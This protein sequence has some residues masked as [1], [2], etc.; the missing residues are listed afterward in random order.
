[1]QV[2][3]KEKRGYI[4]MK[5]DPYK[6]KERFLAWKSKANGRI[7]ELSE[8]N[9]EIL[10]R[11]ISDMEFGLNVANKSVKGAKDSADEIASYRE[12]CANCHVSNRILYLNNSEKSHTSDRIIH[13]SA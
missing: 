13:I 1:M 11:Y 3:Y 4:P 9:S 10:L 8:K 2:P 7:E 5:I 6:H 12:F